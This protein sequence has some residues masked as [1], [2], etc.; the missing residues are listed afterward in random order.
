MK[1]YTSFLRA[2]ATHASAE[3]HIFHIK[4]LHLGHIAKS[5]ALREM[6]GVDSIK[7]KDNGEYNSVMMKKKSDKV[8]SQASVSEFSSGVESIGTYNLKRKR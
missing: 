4:K 7:K 3:K 8:L 2:Y 1:G 5:F 6:N